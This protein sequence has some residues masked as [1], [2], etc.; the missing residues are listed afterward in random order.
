MNNT[1][2]MTPGLAVLMGDIVK[3]NKDQ[4]RPAKPRFPVTILCAG[5]AA[6]Q[7]RESY[8]TL[9]GLVWLRNQSP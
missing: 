2:L 8:T 3:Q 5:K 6:K 4:E 9:R 7:R 1:R